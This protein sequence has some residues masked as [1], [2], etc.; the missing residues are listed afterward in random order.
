MAV[1]KRS[2]SRRRTQHSLQTQV[3]K[4]LTVKAKHGNGSFRPGS[5]GVCEAQLW[6]FSGPRNPLDRDEEPESHMVAAESIH[7]ALKYI[8]WREREFR[9]HKAECVGLIAMLSGSPLD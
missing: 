6:R 5:R 9:I 3:P 4:A 1:T 7:E 8:C 2:G